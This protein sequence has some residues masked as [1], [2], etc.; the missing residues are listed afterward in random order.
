MADAVD[1]LRAFKGDFDENNE[2]L[3]SLKARAGPR[4]VRRRNAD[5]LSRV[6]TSLAA[7]ASA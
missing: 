5:Q 4:V 6:Q 3:A 1:Q 2:I 7:L